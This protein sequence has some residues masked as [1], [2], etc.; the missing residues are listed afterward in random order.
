MT[1][2]SD[3]K[4]CIHY[5]FKKQME[6]IDYLFLTITNLNRVYRKYQSG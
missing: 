6:Q 2:Q 1:K 4:M 3:A 5:I